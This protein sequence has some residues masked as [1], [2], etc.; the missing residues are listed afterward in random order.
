MKGGW[1]SCWIAFAATTTS[2]TNRSAQLRSYA[3]SSRTTGRLSGRRLEALGAAL[4]RIATSDAQQFA[5]AAQQANGTRAG[6]LAEIGSDPVEELRAT[7]ELAL[8]ISAARGDVAA[9]LVAKLDPSCR[10][11]LDTAQRLPDLTTQYL[12]AGPGSPQ[13]PSRFDDLSSVVFGQFRNQLGACNLAG[14]PGVCRTVFQTSRR[15]AESWNQFGASEEG[16]PLERTQKDELARQADALRTQL[17]T[18][19]R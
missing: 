1:P 13:E 6:D 18:I 10:A 2:P 7:S 12:A 15:L 3:S 16:S 19:C 17:Q 8:A 14:L 9:Y 5:A 4:E 11:A